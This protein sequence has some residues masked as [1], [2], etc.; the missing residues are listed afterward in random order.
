MAA[1]GVTAT[2]RGVAYGLVPV[3]ALAATVAVEAAERQGLA[4][5]VDG[6]QSEFGISDFQV[7]LLPAAM[8]VVGVLGSIVIGIL[9]DRSRRTRLLSGA[10]VAW[11]VG[12]VASA[13]APGYAALVAARMAVGAVEGNGPAAVSLLGDYYPVRNRGRMFGL[14]Q[15]GAL[16]G[17]LVGLLAAG[18]A[19][20]AGGW[21]WAFWIWVPVGL[22]VAVWVARIPEPARGDQDGDL[23]VGSADD[24][25][26]GGAKHGDGG[27]EPVDGHHPDHGD[28]HTIGEEIGIGGLTSVDAAAT[29]DLPAATRIGTLDYDRA[30]LGT[31]IRELCRVRTMWFALLALT[32][33]QF[34]LVGLQFWGVEFFKRAH[35]LS[36][37]GA[38]GFTAV[39]GLGAAA[40]VLLGGF[41]SDRYVE[42]GVV[43]ARIL[44][45]AASSLAAPVVLVP[46]FLISNIWLTTPFFIL[47]GLLLTAPVAPG[48]AVLNDVVVAP[49]RGRAAS[50]RGV[51]R[52]LAALSPVLIGGLSDAVG[53]QDALALLTPTY[54]V[55]G[56]LMLLAT[57]T[58]PTDLAFVAEESH[59]LRSDPAS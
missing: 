55:G 52:S 15:G 50:F 48:E 31:V 57:R 59:R 19:V 33:S 49:L 30:G 18:V 37:S 41:V 6:I 51:L 53:L 40:G 35:G 23:R 39:F 38:A 13:L 22:A 45:V 29:L 46:A 26:D 9:A 42:R 21:R 27:V 16:V 34:L 24:E 5:A 25:G 20:S 7:G 10:M 58:Y 43:N 47:G 56:V 4:Q 11:T 14:Y 1:S 36:A 32:L 28:P 12:M 2:R 8:T 17:T 44:V 54:A 3:A